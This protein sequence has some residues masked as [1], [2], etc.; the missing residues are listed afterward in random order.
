[1]AVPVP[2]CS[3]HETRNSFSFSF[4]FGFLNL[5]SQRQIAIMKLRKRPSIP[6]TRLLIFLLTSFLL[7]LTSLPSLIAAK[8]SE[9]TVTKTKLE[10]QPGGLYYFDHSE[11]LL[12]YDHKNG[13]VLRSPN[14]GESWNKIDALPDGKAAMIW[15][16][17]VDHQTAYVLTMGYDHYL[18]HDKGETWTSFETAAHPSPWRE[19]LVFHGT[20]AKSI[21]YHGEVCASFF[22]C[23]EVVRL[24]HPHH[25][26]FTIQRT[27]Y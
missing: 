14:A 2:S 13:N 5:T 23:D 11:V 4:G 27:V 21:I 16:H 20:D 7:L 25:P 6:P 17:P 10:T 8:K 12:L 15:L 19:A 24:L 26:L 9:P 18:T 22:E 3:G 1:L